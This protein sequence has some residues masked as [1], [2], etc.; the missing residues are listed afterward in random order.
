MANSPTDDEEITD[1]PKCGVNGY[2][3]RPGCRNVPY[4]TSILNRI[5]DGFD[6]GALHDG[7]DIRTIAQRMDE[8][9]G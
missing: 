4:I 8:I 5:A 1:C 7:T 3:H 9:L 6:A 2:A